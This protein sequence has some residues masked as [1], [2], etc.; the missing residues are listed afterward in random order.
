MRVGLILSYLQY[1]FN[2]S[3]YN[4]IHMWIVQQLKNTCQQIRNT[5]IKIK[6]L[7]PVVFLLSLFFTNAYNVQPY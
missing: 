5:H 1:A 7:G 3:T 6:V 4:L 2:T